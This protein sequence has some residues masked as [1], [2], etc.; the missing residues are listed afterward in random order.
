M[1]FDRPTD[2]APGTGLVAGFL[3]WGCDAYVRRLVLNECA[4]RSSGQ[5]VFEFDMFDVRLDFD[6]R[7]ALVSDTVT[8]AEAES[9]ALDAFVRLVGG[10]AALQELPKIR[11]QHEQRLL[12]L[13]E[14]VRAAVPAPEVEALR[15]C[16]ARGEYGLAFDRFAY[17]VIER[18]PD[19][20]ATAEKE[21]EELGGLLDVTGRWSRHRLAEDAYRTGPG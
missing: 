3:Q 12:A 17:W 9:M 7:V 21:L 19:L 13:L 16:I 4:A 5:V 11:R 15:D 6:Q 1:D 20:S 14:S 10:D 8:D 18:E 2:A